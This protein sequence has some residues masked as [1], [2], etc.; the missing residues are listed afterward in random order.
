[1]GAV[2]PELAAAP[3]SGVPERAAPE[4]AVPESVVPEPAVPELGGAGAGGVGVG[5][6]RWTS[7]V[8]EL[9]PVLALELGRHRRG[10]SLRECELLARY[11]RPC[12]PFGIPNWARP[13]RVRSGSL[14]RS[15][16]LASPTGHRCSPSMNKPRSSAR[17]W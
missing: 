7:E 16:G 9:V 10:T 2:A 12:R 1:M 4:S 17:R 3:A 8:L 14:C 5:G 6:R 15:Q 11:R 13:R